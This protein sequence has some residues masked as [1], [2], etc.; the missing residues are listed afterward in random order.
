MPEV[1]S[2]PPGKFCWADLATTDATAA[3]TFY[4]T[5][6]DDTV[7]V[8]PMGPGAFYYILQKKGKDVAG[9][10]EQDAEQK[11]NKVPAS[12]TAYFWV[13][14]ADEAAKKIKSLGGRILAEP[15]DVMDV[16]RMAVASDPQGAV[17]AV[18]QAKTHTGAKIFGEPGALAWNELMTTDSAGAI[19]FYTQLFG[20]TTE[21]MPM[22]GMDYTILKIGE[23]NAGGLFKIREDMKGMPPGWVVY[24]AVKNCDQAVQT[25]K[26]FRGQVKTEPHD[27]E[28]TGRFSVVQDPQGAMFAVIELVAASG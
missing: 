22:P 21:K 8:I 28:G 23:E 4:T 12:W 9:M 16:G 2:Y 27:I 24:F 17:F 6:L 26:Q 5:L 19:K 18:W 1:T 7:A 11:K 14:D 25:I 10:A 15:F 13:K 3:R 20:M